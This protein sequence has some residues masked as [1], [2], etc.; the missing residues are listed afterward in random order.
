MKEKNKNSIIIFTANNFRDPLF[1]GTVIV[2]LKAI[3]ADKKFNF[4]VISYESGEYGLKENETKS[5]Y[6]ELSN[7]NIHHYPLK[8]KPGKIKLFRKANEFLKGFFLAGRIAK[9]ENAKAIFALANVAGAFSYIISR[10]YK[11]KLI[12]FTYEPHSEFMTECGVWK[13]SSLKYKLLNR[14]ERKMGMKADYIATGT[15]HMVERLHEWKSKAKIYR[16]PSCIDE[17]IFKFDQQQRDSIRKKLGIE[18]KKVFIYLGKFGDL[19]YKEEI[20]E[21]CKAIE[22]AIPDSFFLILT[23][24]S[25]EEITLLFLRKGVNQKNFHITRAALNDVPNFISAADMGIVAVPPL[26]AQKF[27]SP[28]KVGEYLSCGI[29]YI[30]CKGVSEDD[31]YAVNYNV[32]MVLNEFSSTEVKNNLGKLNE[33]LNENKKE[34][35]LRCRK[36]GI[37]YRG[38]QIAINAFHEI[39]NEIYR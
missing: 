18:N 6:E 29:P 9:K 8:W 38:K 16:I 21:L 12:L 2:Y 11:L 35:Q 24:N 1:Y 34:Q 4:H 5:F 39:F 31:S 7:Y 20:G 17:E 10:W 27:R 25:E 23:P 28:I 33:L 36:I 19:Y 14:Y 30:V 37:E 32:G 13:K 3:N 15:K 22:S 26:P